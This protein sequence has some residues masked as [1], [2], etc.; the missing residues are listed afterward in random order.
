[1]VT[2]DSSEDSAAFNDALSTP[3]AANA[4]RVTVTYQN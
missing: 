3:G 2:A 4:P 1:M